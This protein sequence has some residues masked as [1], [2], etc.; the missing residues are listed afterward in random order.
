M[1]NYPGR[2][3]YSKIE[4]VV[5]RA[6]RDNLIKT[7]STYYSINGISIDLST[8]ENEY[9][10]PFIEVEIDIVYDNYS[11]SLTTN[12]WLDKSEDYNEGYLS[13]EIWKLVE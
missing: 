1:I 11:Q 9:D 3:L 4:K 2:D 8:I 6:F 7:D 13:C 10:L 5:D 12:Y